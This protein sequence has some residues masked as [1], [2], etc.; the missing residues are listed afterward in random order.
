MRC[1]PKIIAMERVCCNRG[2]PFL[3]KDPQE[4]HEDLCGSLIAFE[5]YMLLGIQA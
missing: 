3:Q 5:Y 4:P 1:C 2:T